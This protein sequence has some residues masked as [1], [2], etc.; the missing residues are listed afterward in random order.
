[1][2]LYQ[3]LGPSL[4]WLPLIAKGVVRLNEN[5]NRL[6]WTDTGRFAAVLTPTLDLG[7]KLASL[8]IHAQAVSSIASM[9]GIADLRSALEATR[10]IATVGAVASVANV[11]VSIAGFAIVLHR[12][13][14]IEGKLDHMVTAVDE[15]K[16]AVRSI[17][18]S[19][20]VLVMARIAAAH[21]NLDRSLVAKAEERTALARDARRL[22]Q[23]SRLRY[24]ELWRRAD[25]WRSPTIEVATALEL[26]G[27][28]IASALGEMQAEF[29]LG[30]RGAFAHACRSAARDLSETMSFDPQVALRLR[31]DAIARR[32]GTSN[33]SPGMHAGLINGTIGPLGAQIR[34]AHETTL[35][36]IERMRSFEG[37]ADLPEQL[38]IAP[39]ELLLL[40]KESPG[41]DVVAIGR[42]EQTS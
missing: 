29:V 14:R 21:E 5:S 16:E 23:E 40:T 36:A 4:K 19:A 20:D 15:L 18:A 1:M 33:L 27:R 9:A 26:Q 42:L 22:F 39:H 41:V 35:D 25:P 34:V 6:V 28:Y 7:K 24:L 30:D 12:L 17:G 3:L 10:M 38:G 32:A 11:G 13:G 31:S 2:S 37:D 8:P